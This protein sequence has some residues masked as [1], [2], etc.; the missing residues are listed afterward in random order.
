MSKRLPAEYDGRH[1]IPNPG[2]L[3][4]ERERMSWGPIGL[5]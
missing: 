3:G 5:K 4:V 1:S 2:F